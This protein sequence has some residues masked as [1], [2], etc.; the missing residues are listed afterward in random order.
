MTLMG[1]KDRRFKGIER[2]VG[3]FVVLA[4]AAILIVFFF[5]GVQRDLFTP[6]ARLFF[7]AESASGLSEGQAVKYKGFRIGKV[8]SVSLDE[9]GQVD[10]ELLINKKHMKWV[11]DGAKAQL[12]Q[13]GVI[14]ES[15]I[16]ITRG[17]GE[18]LED[19]ASLSFKRST[20]L[21]DVAQ[22]L[23]G[24]IEDFLSEM[25]KIVHYIN[26]PEGD[27][28]TS[29]GN[30]ERFTVG[31]EDT[32]R[33]LDD[34]ISGKENSV[35]KTLGN[36]DHTLANIDELAVSLKNETA[37]SISNAFDS[38]GQA[39]GGIGTVT[40]TVNAELPAMLGDLKQTLGD[41]RAVA[42][43]IANAASEVPP[44]VQE[45]AL[46]VDDSREV[47]GA[48]KDIWPVKNHIDDPAQKVIGVDSYE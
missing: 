21:G 36:I 6:K 28:K 26:D 43:N 15:I 14:G 37:P 1:E 46:L 47:V 48:V 8:D 10:V 30:I 19:G 7:K 12:I 20:G 39:A 9:I 29:L 4:V 41:L 34:V 11:R 24:Q 23:K 17:D 33:K 42:A 13:E 32:R 44:L 38:A 25:R 3:T 2:K 18:P 27:I 31:L 35:A 16:E 5:M 40:N 45:G 22:E